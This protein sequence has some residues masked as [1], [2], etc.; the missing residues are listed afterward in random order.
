MKRLDFSNKLVISIALS[1]ACAFAVWFFFGPHFRR[2][3]SDMIDETFYCA[4]RYVALRE[5][6]FGTEKPAE[7]LIRCGFGNLSFELPSSMAGGARIVRSPP[8]SVWLVFDDAGRFMQ[9]LL[10]DPN[11]GS[12]VSTPPPELVNTS[13]PGLLATIAAVSSE[14]FSFGSTRSELRIYE[15]AIANRKLIGLEAQLMDRFAVRSSETVD[16]ILISADSN[17]NVS[18]KQICSWLVWEAKEG[19][20]S[21]S[22]YFGHSTRQDV[23]WIHAIAKTIEFNSA[24]KVNSV[25]APDFSTM[26]DDEMLKKLK[27]DRLNQP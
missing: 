27:F 2:V 6:Q 23:D 8:S 4:P 13:V 25:P 21:S 16:I 20:E 15:W 9:I 11:P 7:Q 5:Y 18:E 3:S 14:D 19:G 24:D 10:S 17:A 22:I 1:A 12:M 26:T